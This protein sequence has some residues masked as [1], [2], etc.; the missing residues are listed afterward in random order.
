M[1][2]YTVDTTTAKIVE[3]FRE[4]EEKVARERGGFS[5][6]GLFE[7]EELPG[8]W[9]L[10]AA[11]PWLS[12][13]RN[14]IKE[15]ID[16]LSAFFDVK[17]WKIVAAVVPIR[18]PSEFVDAVTSKYRVEHEVEEIGRLYLSGLY[19]NHAFLITANPAPT[20]APAQREPVAA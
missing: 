1:T 16:A 11:A 7:L 17:D 18:E 3:K 15:L 4:A 13:S 2:R 8:S 19:I 5:L 6:F 14:D 20:P 9:D 10:V 12:T